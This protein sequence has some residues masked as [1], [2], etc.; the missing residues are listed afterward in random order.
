MASRSS[1]SLLKFFVER[2]KFVAPVA[3]AVSASGAWP[4][5]ANADA[6]AASKAAWFFF[7]ASSASVLMDFSHTSFQKT[8]PAQFSTMSLLEGFSWV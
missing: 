1:S 8:V 3:G 2:A 5:L 7:F 4:V 6:C